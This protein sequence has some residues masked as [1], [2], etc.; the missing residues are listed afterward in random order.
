[1]KYALLLSMLASG[2]GLYLH[3]AQPLLWNKMVVTATHS[4]LQTIVDPSQDAAQSSTGTAAEPSS[5]AAAASSRLGRVFHPPDPLPARGNWT[6]T[7]LDGHTFH[8]VVVQK[9]E[10]DAVTIL[11]RDGGARIDIADL[12]ADIQQLLNYDPALAAAAREDRAQQDTISEASMDQERVQAQEIAAQ[13]RADEDANVFGNV[14]SYDSG[15][16]VTDEQYATYQSDVNGLRNHVFIS[17]TGEVTG[18]PYYVRRYEEERRFMAIHDRAKEE[19]FRQHPESQNRPGEYHGQVASNQ[20]GQE[21][22]RDG[23]T[24]EYHENFAAP[25]RTEPETRPVEAQRPPSTP[26]PMGTRG[27]SYPTPIYTPGR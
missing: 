11:H 10:P 24:Q 19:E 8:D 14:G 26:A 13:K 25:P 20:A 22:R 17:G 23:A 21:F 5:F 12:P 6:W 4:L 2:G 27:P 18:D 3:T 1:M 7:T 16:V 9:V 15:R